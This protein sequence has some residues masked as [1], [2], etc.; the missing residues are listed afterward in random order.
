M[1]RYPGMKK[2]I[3]AGGRQALEQRTADELVAKS[4]GFQ[5]A[6]DQL[7]SVESYVQPPDDP[8]APV[9][10]GVIPR[11]RAVFVEWSPALPSLHIETVQ[12]LVTR[13][14]DGATR[15]ELVREA[16]QGIRIADLTPED[17]TVE[18]RNEDRWGRVSV[19]T[20]PATFEPLP[21]AADQISADL[22]IAAGQIVPYLPTDP[23]TPSPFDTPELFTEGLFDLTHMAAVQRLNVLPFGRSLYGNYKAVASD[24]VRGSLFAPFFQTPDGTWSFADED[25]GTHRLLQHNAGATVPSYLTPFQY[26]PL[27]ADQQYIFAARVRNPGVVARVVSVTVQ[28]SPDGSTAGPEVSSPQVSIPGGG[29]EYTVFVGFARGA[30]THMR[31]RYG[32]HTASGGVRW[33]KNQLVPADGR[34]LATITEA[35]VYSMPVLGVDGLNARLISTMD[36]AAV[37]GVFQDLSVESAKMAGLVVD[38]LEAG[39][40]DVDIDLVVGGVV[41]AG[42]TVI[43]HTGLEI[44][45]GAK[46]FGAFPSEG[47]ADWITPPDTNTLPAPYAGIGFAS[48]GGGVND[49]RGVIIAAVGEAGAGGVEGRIRLHASSGNTAELGLESVGIIDLFSDEDTGGFVNIKEDLNVTRDIMATRYLQAGQRMRPTESADVTLVPAGGS[50]TLAHGRGTQA[51]L[52]MVFFRDSFGDWRPIVNGSGN[53]RVATTDNGITVINDTADSQRFRMSYYG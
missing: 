39:S 15:L 16:D 17:H 13:V 5:E 8:P 33:T 20:A 29:V 11:M 19:W 3:R 24:N 34:D 42:G 35:P 2:L 48:T 52:Y 38:K 22:E 27:P 51:T 1:S 47:R 26:A 44:D 25:D 30:N 21:T 41:N 45:D 36:I 43:S 28:L 23:T 40:L 50:M 49:Q 12:V 14:S 31:F 32:L 7:A 46:T 9:I 37:R 10:T 18:T 53:F 6:Q 4:Q